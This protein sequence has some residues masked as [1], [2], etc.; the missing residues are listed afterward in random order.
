VSLDHHDLFDQERGDNPVLAGGR[1]MRPWASKEEVPSSIW[2]GHRWSYP[3]FSD[4]RYLAALNE[5]YHYSWKRENERKE[6]EK[7]RAKIGPGCPTA[8]CAN[9]ECKAHV[10][11]VRDEL[12][13][14]LEGS[15]LCDRCRDTV[16]RLGS[17]PQGNGWEIRC[18]SSA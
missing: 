1:I 6:A 7:A 17:L 10:P 3:R 13:Y 15:R 5:T 12:G 2:E 18:L 9:V 14:F 8:P 4:E 16:K 11:I